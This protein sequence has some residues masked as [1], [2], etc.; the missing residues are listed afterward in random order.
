[1]RPHASTPVGGRYPAGYPLRRLP[2]TSYLELQGSQE[3]VGGHT[4]EPVTVGV[5]GIRDPQRSRDQVQMHAQL[6]EAQ[7]VPVKAGAAQLRVVLGEPHPHPDMLCLDVE[8][9]RAF[10]IDQHRLAAAIEQ[11]VVRAKLAVDQG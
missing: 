1:M 7:A 5:A 8:V 6:V 11:D 3:V 9:L 10:D 2:E 4:A